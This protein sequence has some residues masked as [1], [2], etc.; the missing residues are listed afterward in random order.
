MTKLKP[1]N[2]LN[3]ESAGRKV[4]KW[5]QDESEASWPKDMADFRNQ[6]AED[7]EI[8]ERYQTIEVVQGTDTH[9]IL[10]LPPKNQ[11]TQSEQEVVEEKKQEE[12]TGQ[13]QSY[14]PPEF[15][16]DLLVEGTLDNVSFFYSRISDYTI[17]GCR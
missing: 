6:L 11:V 8:P 7:V 2:I 15:Y 13:P 10:R 1:M 3:Y 5:A 16:K 9:F 14:N 17:R 12:Q 4:V